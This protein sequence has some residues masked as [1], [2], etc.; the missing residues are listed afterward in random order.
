MSLVCSCGL[1]RSRSSSAQFFSSLAG[2]GVELGD[3]LL[4]DDA[5][6]VGI[7]RR[8]DIRWLGSGG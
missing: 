8:S 1:G 4:K 2:F 5:N 6:D 7:T 3:F